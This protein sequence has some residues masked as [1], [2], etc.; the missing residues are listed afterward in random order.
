[1]RKKIVVGFLVIIVVA[2]RFSLT[3]EA[4]AN[5]ITKF[6]N[7]V[8]VSQKDNVY[9]YANPDK[10]SDINGILTPNS[11]GFI[12]K[13][14]VDNDMLKITSGC[15]SG[16][17]DA[18]YLQSGDE[19]RRMIEENG[20]KIAIVDT[21]IARLY[22]ENSSNSDVINI[23][24]MG[25]TMTVLGTKGDWIKAISESGEKG[26]MEPSCISISIELTTA[27]PYKESTRK[28][29]IELPDQHKNIITPYDSYFS[30]AS[31]HSGVPV[32]L[33]K[34]VAK[35][36]SGFNENAVSSSGAVGIMQLMEGTATAYGC[37]NRYE[38]E[39]NIM[40]GALYLA[41]LITRFNNIELALAAYNAGPA[42]VEKYG[43]IPPFEE[44]QNYVASVMNSYC[45][46][47]DYSTTV[48]K[49][50]IS[51]SLDNMNKLSSENTAP[52]LG[53]IV[54]LYACQYVGNPY[55]WGGNDL[56]N[57]VDCSGFVKEVYKRFGV[58]LPRNSQDLREVGSQVCVGWNESL[59]KPGDIICYDGHV[60]I[61]IGNNS[62]VHAAGK[63][64]G[65]KI[66]KKAD[67]RSVIC[68]R[69]IF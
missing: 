63:K 30:N 46:L 17:V 62:I 67:Y 11:I 39:S 27:K 1:M 31:L 28:L 58:E 12:E 41:S 5:T 56:E 37:M 54:A 10:N 9:I 7:L 14:E 16:Y 22:K 35:K 33:L 45:G 65:I 34:A 61:Y 6:D 55:K 29:M 3:V 36:E 15:I 60:S 47:E 26:Y 69:R 59:V 44:T 19:A 23:L 50:V 57:G 20:R 49:S 53:T 21:A 51:V 64:E 66:T 48:S 18:S 43:G 32:E 40:A 24:P 2:S 8:I 25:T 13:K 42:N 38:A 52:S 68:V 4:M